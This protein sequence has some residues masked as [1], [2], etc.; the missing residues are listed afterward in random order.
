MG[1]AAAG[2]LAGA[3]RA[4]RRSGEMF[5]AADDAANGALVEI[6]LANVLA[7]LGR[8]VEALELA[9]SVSELAAG[10]DAEAQVG[11]RIASARALAASGDAPAA[12][13][14]AAE[15][16]ERARA[17][18]FV[19]LQADAHVAMADV[20]TASSRTA[21]ALEHLRR[22]EAIFRAKGQTTDADACARR[23]QRVEDGV[24]G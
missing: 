2:D 6:D 16:L 8:T 22:A 11:W 19:V 13:R 18:G 12:E 1:A 10:Y 24:A 14:L 21:D 15:A 3:A 17:T 5:R 9:S 4:P 7:R 23:V 20:L